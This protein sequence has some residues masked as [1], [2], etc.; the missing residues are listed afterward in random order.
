[1]NTKFKKIFIVTVAAMILTMPVG[2]MAAQTTSEEQTSLGASGSSSGTYTCIENNVKVWKYNTKKYQI[3]TL[4][5]GQAVTVLRYGK[6]IS[7]I[8][9]GSTIGYVESASLSQ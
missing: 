4:S 6:E 7:K 1:M 5:K 2:A 8:E 9:F 3:G